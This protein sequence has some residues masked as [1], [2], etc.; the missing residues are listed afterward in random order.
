MFRRWFDELL[1]LRCCDL[2]RQVSYFD[3]PKLW[4]NINLP[5]MTDMLV[6]MILQIL[7]DWMK[8]GRNQKYKVLYREY[9]Y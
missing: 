4:I 6:D 3:C 2:T 1:E 7:S 8:Q 5:K 9:T